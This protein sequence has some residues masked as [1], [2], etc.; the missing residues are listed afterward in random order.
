MIKYKSTWVVFK[1]FGEITLLELTTMNASFKV[2]LLSLSVK[3][4]LNLSNLICC[5]SVLVHLNG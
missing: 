1:N 5:N 3:C 2:L 4:I